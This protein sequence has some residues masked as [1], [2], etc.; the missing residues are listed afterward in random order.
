MSLILWLSTAVRYHEPTPYHHALSFEERKLPDVHR[1]FVGEDHKNQELSLE[2][3][4]I[5]M[6][7]FKNEDL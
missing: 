5:H 4:S 1:R 2:D 7:K 3:L 6:S